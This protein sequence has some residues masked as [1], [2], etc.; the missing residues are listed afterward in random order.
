M[1]RKTI[2]DYSLGSARKKSCL[3][4]DAPELDLEREEADRLVRA[5]GIDSVM[6]GSE[7]SPVQ[8]KGFDYQV[9]HKACSEYGINL[10][11]VS[12][13]VMPPANMIKALREAGMTHTSKGDDLGE[14][15]ASQVRAITRS[16]LQDLVKQR[17]Q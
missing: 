16:K 7:A 4:D 14:V 10:S 6:K 13:D 12:S 9:F 8:N 17:N 5:Y 11:T 3:Y 2:N 15:K 1:A